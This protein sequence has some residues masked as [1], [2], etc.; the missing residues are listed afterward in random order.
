MMFL[1]ARPISR[2]LMSA[3]FAIGAALF[4]CGTV[5]KARADVRFGSSPLVAEAGLGWS[6]ACSAILETCEVKSRFVSL[7]RS[8]APSAGWIVSLKADPATAPPRIEE[9]Q[10]SASCACDRIVL[11]VGQDLK[12]IE[13][14][15]LMTIANAGKATA[16]LQLLTSGQVEIVLH[17]WSTSW[18][19]VTIKTAGLAEV[20]AWVDRQQERSDRNLVGAAPPAEMPLIPASMVADT[21][22]FTDPE[23]TAK[24]LPAPVRRLFD[25]AVRK[26]CQAHASDPNRPYF[27]AHWVERDRVVFFVEC[28]RPDLGPT[29]RSYTATGP[30]YQDARALSLVQWD[31]AAVTSGKQPAPRGEVMTSPEF[32]PAETLTLNHRRA[33]IQNCSVE[34]SYRWLKG[35]YRLLAVRASECDASA[36]SLPERTIRFQAPAGE[37]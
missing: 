17:T 18:S 24:E 31:N 23:R 21:D 6:A 10:A 9:V 30:S 19:Q 3:V 13:R 34:H 26:G 25:R 7:R 12:F 4:S 33:G 29:Y 35:D 28:T 2:V 8:S 37:Q 16:V 27:D 32:G 5:T 14:P 11:T 22:A 15:D 1:F 20:L 36:R